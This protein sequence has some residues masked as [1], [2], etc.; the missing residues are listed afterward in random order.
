MLACISS[1]GNGGQHATPPITITIS[2]H[3]AGTL[4][5]D[6]YIRHAVDRI[7]ADKTPPCSVSL[8]PISRRTIEIGRNESERVSVSATMFSVGFCEMD[9]FAAVYNET[10]YDRRIPLEPQTCVGSRN[11]PSSEKYIHF[12]LVRTF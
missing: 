7:S 12:L 4:I 1:G 5:V 9:A 6:K 3:S 10:W 8:W 2:G 11:V